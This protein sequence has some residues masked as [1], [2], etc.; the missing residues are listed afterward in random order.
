MR[1]VCI[2]KNTPGHVKNRHPGPGHEFV[3]PAWE[4]QV[5]REETQTMDTPER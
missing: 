3:L 4:I 2:Q 1:R 5:G